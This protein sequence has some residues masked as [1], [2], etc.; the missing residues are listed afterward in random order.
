MRPLLGTF[1]EIGADNSGD[2]SSVDQ[3]INAA[4]MV[5]QTIHNLLSFHELDSELSRINQ[6]NGHFIKVNSHTIRVFRLARGMM[7]DSA[8]LFNCTVGGMMINCGVLPNHG[9]KVIPIGNVSDIEIN[10]SQIRLNRNVKVTLD[11]I[12]KGYAVDCAI[13]AMKRHG[14]IS[15]W[16]NA[17]GDLRVYGN[18]TLPLQRREIDGSFTALGGLK[19]AALASSHVSV[20][21]DVNFPSKIVAENV[22]PTL[23]VWSVMSHFAWRA[24]ALTK[25]ASL[26]N[27]HNRADIVNQLGGKVVYPQQAAF[28]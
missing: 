11:G 2:P 9:G 6:A 18:M 8:G 28:K 5:I 12:A 27:E 23:G 1:I 7:L 25:V 13:A 4:F 16:V 20:K 26:A 21:Y 10:N 24:D 17:G 15:G 14:I 19:N 22:E 3:A